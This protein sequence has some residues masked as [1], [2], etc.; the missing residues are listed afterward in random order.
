MIRLLLVDDQVLLLESLRTVLEHDSKDFEV[1]AVAH[2]GNEAIA[3]VREKKPDVILM[4]IRMP[5]LDGVE[6]TKAI[7]A[8][9][10]DAHILVLTTF[11]DDS[12]VQ[13]AIQW[14]AEGYLLKNMPPAELAHAIRA[15]HSG[16]IMMSPEIAKKLV[17]ETGRQ[18]TRA[19]REP[20]LLESGEQLSKRELEV[21]QM[22]A[23]GMGNR[24]ISEKLFIAEQTV[25][26]HVSM[27]YSKLDA[28]D[29]YN[30][31]TKATELGLV[32]PGHEY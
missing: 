5:N 13:H 18:T 12:Y 7:K 1:V 10:P 22:M 20:A 11:D 15:V 31:V 14:G 25:R 3:A 30:A 23:E 2:D 8:E 27:I 9:F 6:A 28:H 4:D 19:D 17:G 26:N 21:L 16:M 24:Q 32:K 29:R